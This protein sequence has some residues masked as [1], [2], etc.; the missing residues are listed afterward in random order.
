MIVLDA[1]ISSHDLAA[2]FG[3]CATTLEH[4]T[5]RTSLWLRTTDSDLY[6]TAGKLSEGHRAR[7]VLFT[8]G[9]CA[10]GSAIIPAIVTSLF[11]SHVR[12]YFNV[13]AS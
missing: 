10:Y 3:N 9:S 5:P 4:M 2:P 7:V 8:T 6:T 11:K 13:A 12:S 1:S